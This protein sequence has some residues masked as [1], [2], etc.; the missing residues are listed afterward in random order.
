MALCLTRRINSLICSLVGYGLV[1]R[2]RRHIIYSLIFRVCVSTAGEKA[3]LARSLTT[4]NSLPSY[5]G[6]WGSRTLRVSKGCYHYAHQGLQV[7]GS[8]TRRQQNP[9]W[10]WFDC[11]YVH[12]QPA[13][14]RACKFISSLLVWW[15][16]NYTSSLQGLIDLDAE[17]AKC[18]KKLQL[19]RLN[20]DKVR[21]VEAQP[22]YVETVPENVRSINEDRVRVLQ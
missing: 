10:V 16:I 2:S 17:I 11:P 3:P 14:P 20:L 15:R 22:D 1:A 19:A 5:T 9:I 7:G 18:E 12:D 6:W 4:M 13:H 8:C 21:K